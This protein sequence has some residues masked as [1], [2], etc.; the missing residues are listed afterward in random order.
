MTTSPSIEAICDLLKLAQQQT[1]VVVTI[2]GRPNVVE[3]NDPDPPESCWQARSDMDR[4]L[5]EATWKTT[6]PGFERLREWVESHWST[7]KDHQTPSGTI[8]TGQNW[9]VQSENQLDD[10]TAARKLIVAAKLYGIEAVAKY[11]DQFAAHGLVEVRRH[12]L[13]KGQPIESAKPL[14]DY[15]TL[16]PY[17]EALR[18]IAAQSD[19]GDISVDWPDRDADNVCALRERYFERVSPSAV[20]KRRYASPLLTDGA[21]RLV[22]LLGLVWG[23]GFRVVGNWRGVPST[24]AAVLPYRLSQGPGA[25]SWPVDLTMKGFGPPPRKRPLAVGELRALATCYSEHPEHARLRLRRAMTRLR[26]FSE[27]LDDDDRVIDLGIALDTLFIEDGEREDRET[28]IPLR[29]AWLYADTVNERRETEAMLRRFLDR[30]REVLGGRGVAPRPG[31]DH[32][33]DARLPVET[34][35][36]TRTCLKTLV[37]DGWPARWS[38]A[39]EPSALRLDPHRTAS[40][41][42]SVKADSLSWSVED[43]RE[44]DRALEA[45]WKTVIE[46]APLPP[47][48]SP[49]TVPELDPKLIERYRHRGIPYV[50]TH[51]ARLY[52][53]HPKWPRTAS[54]PLD[55]R[56]A[57]YCERDVVRH[58]RLWREAALNKGLV[59]VEAPTDPN[60]YHPKDRDTWQEPLLSSHEDNLGVGAG[61]RRT[62]TGNAPDTQASKAVDADDD[63]YPPGAED[64]C[65]APPSDPPHA[66]AAGLEREW[67]RLWEEFRHD[68]NV[69]TNSLLYLLESIHSRHLAERWR[70]GRAKAGSADAVATL[71]EASLVLGADGS[72]P[73]YPKLRAFPVLTGEP[74]LGRTAPAG[75]MEDSV[76]K[77]WVSDV[78]DLWE[79]RYRTQLKH[80]VRHLPGAIRPRQ[81]VLGDLRHIRNNLLHRGIARRGEAASCEVLRWFAKGERMQVRL[82]HVLDFLNQ[83]GWL[84]EGAP[85]ISG[86]PATF[87]TW[88]L[89]RTGQAEEPSPALVSVRPLVNPE[90][91]VS[92]YRYEASIVFENGLFGRTPMGPEYDETAT[93]AKERTRK[94]KNMTVNEQGDLHVPGVGTVPAAQLYSNMLHGERRPA[95]GIPTP[96][97]QFRE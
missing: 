11:A 50:V 70:L 78:Y 56:T 36:V 65:V 17:D 12:W 60:L 58:T 8:P 15:C 62:T 88:H 38:D 23:D 73:T 90:E 10:T 2:D 95:P 97:V 64:E 59:Q 76:Y 7:D 26:N 48:P 94:W 28:L 29:A 93:Q 35:T 4:Y 96:P 3:M 72:F 66:V 61:D 32:D 40:E 19:P 34:E 47:N 79:S 92:R 42:P 49:T 77:A 31:E 5:G 18:E 91:H 68:V 43:Q 51:P 25:A 86:K 53:A 57:Y 1:D 89:D 16:L 9:G 6:G 82:Q 46:E 21:H 30:N 84:T 67:P 81:D 80:E 20:G 22:L 45:V 54:E 41:I 14:D 27:R 85:A 87:S 37:V 33:R 55:E 63:R 13:L 39:T 75:P 69:R 44:I 71:K 83:M 24:V 74:L 52:S